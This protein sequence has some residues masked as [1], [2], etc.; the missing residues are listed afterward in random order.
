MHIHVNI[1]SGA[2]IPF[3]DQW[4]IITYFDTDAAEQDGFN[5]AH[6][7]LERRGGKWGTINIT[8]FVLSI[9]HLRAIYIKPQGVHNRASNICIR[10]QVLQR[11]SIKS[12]SPRTMDCC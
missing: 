2:A 1:H 12:R 11:Y 5:N 9:S 4:P 6:G 10:L 7:N 8:G 3:F